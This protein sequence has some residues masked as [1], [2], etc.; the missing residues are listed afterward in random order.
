MLTRR[1]VKFLNKYASPQ[2][3]HSIAKGI[4]LT[5][6][7][8]AMVEVIAMVLPIRRRYRGPRCHRNDGSWR[9]Q[10]YCLK[11]DA[12]SIALYIRR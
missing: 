11:R 7:N 9:Q 4:P 1:M 8:I 5:E 3:E 10:S 12:T 2:H 6:E